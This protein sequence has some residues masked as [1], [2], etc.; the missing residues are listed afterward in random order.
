MRRTYAPLRLAAATALLG[1]V[2]L[3]VPQ[4]AAAATLT[5]ITA[6][7][8]A[9]ANV[10]LAGDSV[11]NL[12][13]GTTTY[14]GVI[15][16]QGTLTVRAPSGAGTL[17]L[18]KDSDFTLPAARQHQAVH[19][20]AGNHPVV[21]VTDP[22]PPAVI[23]S[24]GATL[25][26]GDGGSTGVIGHYPYA[27]PCYALNQDNIEVDGTLAVP[28]V[29]R[30]F[31]LGTISGSG[32]ISQPRFTW[33]TLELGG[34][35][36]FSGVIGNGTGMNFDTPCSPLALPSARAVLNNGSAILSTPENYTL[37]LHQD[38]YERYYGNDINFHTTPGGLI[39]MGG[40]YSYADGGPDSAP[41]LSDPALNTAA[42][43]HGPNTRGINIE[44]ARV[45]WGDGTT[46]RFFLPATPANSYINIHKNGS[47][48]FDYDGPVTLGTPV[49]GGVY[50]AS[51]STP[52]YA[53]VSLLPTPGNAVTFAVPQNYHGTTTIGAG[54]TL[55]LGTGKAGG[56]S[57]L[58]TG[59]PADAV[60]D[61]GALVARDAAKPLVLSRISG[62]GS[63]T[64]AG[65][66]KTTLAGGVAYTGATTVAGG[67]L[68]LT[69]GAS[70]AASSGLNLTSNGAV[71][72]LSAA[73]DQSVRGLSGVAGSSLVLGAHTLT[74]AANRASTYAG[75]ISGSGGGLTKSGSST[76]TL[77]G[78]SATPGGTWQLSRGTLAL[79]GAQIAASGFNQAPGTT[80]AVTVTDPADA[81]LHLTGA[82]RLAGTLA[83]TLPAGLADG[84]RVTLIHSTAATPVTGAFAG[85][86]E[87]AAFTSGGAALQISYRG[88]SGHDVVVTV[89]RT[90]G[91][92]AAGT[93]SG[94]SGPGSR[95]A[96]DATAAS[97]FSP[98]LLTLA[99]ALA[100]LLAL[101]AG[102]FILRRRP[103][104]S[105]AGGRRRSVR[106]V[107]EG[108][109][110]R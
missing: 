107:R 51:L 95:A 70:L 50:H 22:D 66:A 73:A 14:N 58:L 30:N 93:A 57:G 12:P 8:T 38:F 13:S 34:T 16:G 44:G 5:D 77:S 6:R 63:F 108:H 4:H 37:T 40:V 83:L 17:V 9:G 43:A 106:R 82:A 104:R 31:N 64:Q 41:S 53:D 27:T 15:S 94:R 84:T 3:T 80:L 69:G 109:G 24:A 81:P 74:V 103:A 60:A 90:S 91:A 23:V 46:D 42:L 99:A 19:I 78:R 26:Y 68:A 36:P 65:P 86:P 1:S 72:D 45:Q 29:S 56:D 88:G 54:A 101:F 11:V 20:S 97:A 85:L 71:L 28:I 35:Y 32:L 47:L 76:L 59:A 25:Q 67:T 39:V 96:A 62:S 87:G 105:R 33:G 75:T 18:T 49:S 7:I 79:D 61:D 2:L 98:R 102:F 110:D 48:A 92:A 21:T 10:T 89:G 52:A 55:L 100:L